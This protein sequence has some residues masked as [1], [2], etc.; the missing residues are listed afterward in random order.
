MRPTTRVITQE[1]GCTAVA[2]EPW[3]GALGCR[4]HR[5]IGF[6]NAAG[7]PM[8]AA[9]AGQVAFAG[10]EDDGDG[11]RVLLVEAAAGQ[12]LYGH[13]CGSPGL[14]AGQAVA[15]GDQIGQMGT[16]G[17]SSGNQLHFAVVVD[18]MAVNPWDYLPSETP[19]Q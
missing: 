16:T 13:L 12:T 3:N 15:Q 2:L 11:Y 7:T 5:G 18:G 6:A 17:A 1:F 19:T 9:K 14:A 8:H 10:W 4:F